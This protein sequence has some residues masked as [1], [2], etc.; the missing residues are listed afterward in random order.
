MVAYVNV[1]I[2]PQPGVPANKISSLWVVIFTENCRNLSKT[3]ENT[4]N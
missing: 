3:T 2:Q 1:I 4:D